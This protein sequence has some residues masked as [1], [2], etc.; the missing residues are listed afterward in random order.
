MLWKILIV[1]PESKFAA[2]HKLFT[3]FVEFFIV[4]KIEVVNIPTGS[5]RLANPDFLFFCR[6]Y[7]RLEAL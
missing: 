5:D 2:A 3:I 1:K 4:G 6:I 7:F